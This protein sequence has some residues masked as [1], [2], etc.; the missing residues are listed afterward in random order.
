ME[1]RIKKA[2]LLGLMVSFLGW[3]GNSKVEAQDSEKMERLEK[4]LEKLEQREKSRYK[5]REKEILTY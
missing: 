3:S 4:R 2:F 1:K 5:K